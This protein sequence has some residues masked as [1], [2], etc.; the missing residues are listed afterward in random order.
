MLLA[1]RRELTKPDTIAQ[2]PSLTKAAARTVSTNFPTDRIGEFIDLA[3]ELDVK[4]VEQVV[5][6]P[7]YSVRA[8]GPDVTD[9]RVRLDMD[10]LAALSIELFGSASR[11]AA[12]AP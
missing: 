5:L 10:R 6:G 3:L 12:T 4:N 7:P 11:Y 9:Y 1:L 8:R 2:I